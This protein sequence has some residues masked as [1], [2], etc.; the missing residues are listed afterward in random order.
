MKL[1]VSYVVITLIGLF[2]L[3]WVRRNVTTENF[4]EGVTSCTEYSNCKDCL[5]GKVDRSSSQCYWNPTKNMCG[6]FS[7]SG[8]GS[9]CSDDH[10]HDHSQYEKFKRKVFAYWFAHHKEK[11]N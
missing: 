5:S 7:G 4:T 9:S 1:T 10:N 11:N 8:Y 2:I 3:L 6:S